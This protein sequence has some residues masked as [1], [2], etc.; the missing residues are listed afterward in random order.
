M[1]LPIWAIYMK[2]CYADSELNISKGDFDVPVDLSINVD[3]TNT[4]VENSDGTKVKDDVPDDLD[5]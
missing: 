5:F 2:S 1:A 3:C 4:S